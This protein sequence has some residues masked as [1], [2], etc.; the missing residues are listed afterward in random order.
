MFI[1]EYN[2]I[3]YYLSDRQISDRYLIPSP[4]PTRPQAGSPK[5]ARGGSGGL[6]DPV[7]KN[8][9]MLT[10]SCIQ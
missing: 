10:V 3:D 2:Q 1:H 9:L 6:T 5:P 8:E 4:P 7:A